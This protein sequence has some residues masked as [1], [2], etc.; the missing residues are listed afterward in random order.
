MIKS[1][2]DVTNIVMPKAITLV[3]AALLP[4]TLD[5]LN[6]EIY[7]LQL[8]PLLE[9]PE[10]PLQERFMS[11]S[12]FK[13]Y[14]NPGSFE[15]NSIVQNAKHHDKY[16][17]VRLLQMGNDWYVWDGWEANHD[18]MAGL[19]SGMGSWNNYGEFHFDPVEGD[20]LEGCD[21][22]DPILQHMFKGRKINKNWA[23]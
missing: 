18:R 4:E 5:Q 3:D 12:G 13:V 17:S 15:F 11:V 1:F 21:T 19:L 9:E 20:Y 7:L 8:K 16:G 10:E 6:E 2:K 14:K 23:I 22:G